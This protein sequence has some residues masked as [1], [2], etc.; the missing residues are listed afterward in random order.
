MRLLIA[1]GLIAVLSSWAGGAAAAERPNILWITAE[2]MSPTLGCYGDSYATTP[3]I[4]ALA[5]E[6]TRYSHAFATSPVCSPSRACLINACI[7][8]TQGAHPMRSLFPL[9][10][11]M[12]GFPALLRDAGYYTTNN[13]KTDY[14]SGSEPRIIRHSWDESSPTAH[15]RN[16]PAGK[17]FF[18]VFNLMT[19]HQSRTMVWPQEQFEAEVQSQLEANEVNDPADVPVPPYYP[20]TPLVRQ[21]IARFYDCVTVMDEQVGQ[22]LQQLEADELAD[23]TIVFFYSD[24]GSG[25]P[26]HKR[27]LL[28]S[29]MRVPLV[30]RIPE[31]YRDWAPTAAGEWTDRLVCFE[32]F[33]PT[34]LNLAGIERLPEFMRGRAFLGPFEAD[35]HEHVFGHRDRV[36][37]II[38]KARSVR[39]RDF[40][41]IRNYM[42]HRGYNQQT[43]WVDQGVVQQDF[44]A[45]AESG[46]ATDAQS[47]YLSA[48]RPREEL[49]DC[50][51]DP[52]NLHNLAGSPEHHQTLAAMRQLLQQHVVES[53]DLGFVP[54]VELW[55]HTDGT[56]PMQWAR[57]AEFQADRI[58]AAA[59]LVGSDCFAAIHDALGDSDVSVRYWGAVASAA[60]DRLPPELH[61]ALRTALR[62]PSPAVRIEAAGALA[63]H[64]DTQHAY[65]VLEQLLEQDDET[66]LLYTARTIELLAD[67]R[68]RQL[69]QAL[70]DRFEDAP[71]DMAWFIRFST[72]GYLNRLDQ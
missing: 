13:V 39:S 4:D 31:R 43:A 23:D 70:F 3:N 45:L 44:Y 54:E 2:D 67:S 69:M 30:I 53:R 41:Y 21:T 66:V 62:D 36:D 58:L 50:R 8:T 11:E 40:L 29:G 1:S 42:P 60:A 22:L 33:G 19:T 38:D 59:E 16:R 46:D 57:T 12:N 9:P 55:E 35:P 52:L 64:G 17:P 34:V 26:R 25:M 15:W 18:S 37:E 24:H 51:T 47:Q 68:H 10:E 6:S 48:T 14:N 27:V 72:R 28:D 63:R 61:Q 7:A 20:D 5:Q 71:G 32:D 65:P 56:T 49:Y